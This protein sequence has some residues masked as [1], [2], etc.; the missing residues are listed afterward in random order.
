[1]NIDVELTRAKK[2]MEEG[3]DKYLVGKPVAPVYRKF[4]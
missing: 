3:I 1:M 4:N 2:A